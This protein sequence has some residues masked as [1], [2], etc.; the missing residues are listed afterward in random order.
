MKKIILSF[1]FILIAK[2]NIA[3]ADVDQQSGG[4]TLMSSS[5]SN[6]SFE[7]VE[8]ANFDQKVINE[9]ENLMVFSP[10]LD[11]N[12]IHL[13]LYNKVNGETSDFQLDLDLISSDFQ[14]VIDSG[15]KSLKTRR[16]ENINFYYHP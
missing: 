1:L 7:K 15:K 16:W 14:S 11:K 2:L 4:E 13:Y 6:S 10:K 8:I 3:F 12:K 5:L 9:K